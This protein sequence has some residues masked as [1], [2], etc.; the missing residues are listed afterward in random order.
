MQEI[1]N[2]QVGLAGTYN[3]TSFMSYVFIIHTIHLL[4]CIIISFLSFCFT[5]TT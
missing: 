5:F 2:S 4:H 3:M 1:S